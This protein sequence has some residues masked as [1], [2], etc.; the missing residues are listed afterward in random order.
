M[1]RLDASL[2][3]ALTLSVASCGGTDVTP[4]EGES[5]SEGEACAESEIAVG[6]VCVRP[7]V[8]EAQRT[9]CGEITENCDPEGVTTPN[10]A[11]HE[12][13]APAP[14]AGPAQVTLTGFVDV[15]GHG[16]DADG[17]KVQI[18]DSER[19]DAQI[20]EALA[21]GALDADWITTTSFGADTLYGEQIVYTAWDDHDEP[22]PGCR[23]CPGEDDARDGIACALPRDDCDPPCDLDANEYCGTK[24]GEARCIQGRLRW[25]CRYAVP[26]VPTNRYLTIR[27][28]GEDEQDDQAWSPMLQYNNYL[29]A[30]SL[31]ISDGSYELKVNVLSYADYVSI[32]NTVIGVP[33]ADERG[34][35]AGEVRDCDDIRLSFAQVGTFPEPQRYTF[36]NG[37]PVTTLPAISGLAVGTNQDGIYA[38]LDIPAGKVEVAALVL[39]AG[40]PLTVGHVTASVLP[41]AV[42]VVGFAERK[43]E[44]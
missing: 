25:E 26:D 12:G 10:F 37:N 30:D 35:V 4:R 7:P 2:V 13:D 43:P 36:F 34:A 31:L 5:E 38:A 18:F 1:L 20:A 22:P 32:P 16:P 24:D 39:S 44:P 15:F 19:L 42:T 40:V 27:T 9:A 17:V 8:E 23:A 6:A 11:C 29:F 28:A 41:G 33:I 21:A 3:L 14:P